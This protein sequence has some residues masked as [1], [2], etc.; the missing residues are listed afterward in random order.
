MD[1]ITQTSHV[2]ND[3]TIYHVPLEAKALS[4]DGERF[5]LHLSE[6]E[7]SALYHEIREHIIY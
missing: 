5:C 7:I 3:E 1:T 6:D 4:F 2:Q